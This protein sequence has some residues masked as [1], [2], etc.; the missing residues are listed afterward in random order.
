MSSI[1]LLVV[2]TVACTKPAPAPTLANK[3]VA[4]GPITP[5]KEPEGAGEATKAR[6]SS[7]SRV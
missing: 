2:T 1:A 6:R 3:P 4:A 7:R 5:T